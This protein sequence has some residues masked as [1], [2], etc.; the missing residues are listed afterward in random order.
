MKERLIDVE[1][2]VGKNWRET[3]FKTFHGSL[4]LGHTKYWKKKFI[5]R[6]VLVKLLNV[7]GKLNSLKGTQ[8][9]QLTYLMSDFSW[10]IN[11][12]QNTIR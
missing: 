3:I 5:T 12:H 4:N 6:V 2:Q 10:T 1:V 7:K 11:R 8:T 9:R